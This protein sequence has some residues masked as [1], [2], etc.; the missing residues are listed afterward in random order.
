MSA[1]S[2]NGL[3]NSALMRPCKHGRHY[4]QNTTIS[5]V[6]NFD[7]HVSK[8]W[9]FLQNFSRGF[10]INI[11]RTIPFKGMWFS[12]EGFKNISIWEMFCHETFL[13]LCIPTTYDSSCVFSK[14]AT[15][16]WKKIV[17]GF[18]RLYTIYICVGLK[19]WNVS[20]N[21]RECLNVQMVVSK[22]NNYSWNSKKFHKK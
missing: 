3:W 16:F 8:L 5:N 6:Q 21:Q 20:K 14:K 2:Q 15:T 1:I 4:R 19:Q 13:R 10:V 22:E 9:P 18:V 12:R 17:S 7:L 11:F